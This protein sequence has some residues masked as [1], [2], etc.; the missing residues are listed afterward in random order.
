MRRRLWRQRPGL[1]L[2]LEEFIMKKPSHHLLLCSSSRVVGE[3]NG[4]CTRRD[5]PSLIQYL[6]EGV[7]E[8]G[9]DNVL[10]S[11]TGCLKMCDQGPIL[12]V[13]PE[14]WWY[15]KVDE[16]RVDEILDAL[17]E[18]RPAETLLVA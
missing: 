16:D 7:D 17:A 8:R 10:V 6:Q 1:R 4:T 13:Y 18:G 14:G 15:G 9:I 2:N 11:N 5:A 3:P 12:V